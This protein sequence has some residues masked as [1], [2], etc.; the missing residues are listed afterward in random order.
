MLRPRLSL[1]A[2]L[3]CTAIGSWLGAT[4]AHATD[5]PVVAVL[6][7]DNNTGN[8]SF[9]VLKKGFA[10]M[11]ITDL[12]AIDELVVVER[13]RLQALLD[14]IKLQQAAFFDPAT[15][16][17][18]GRGLGAR[19][20]ITGAFYATTPELRIDVRMID[21]SSGQVMLA[22]KVVGAE[23]D[24][25]KLEQALVSK[26]VTGLK[27]RVLSKAMP[28]TR[29][30]DLTTLLEYSRGVDLADQGNYQAASQAMSLVIR[31]APSFALARVRRDELIK[32]LEES[33]TRR[34]QTSAQAFNAVLKSTESYF[35]K[36]GSL[37]GMSLDD[38]KAYIAFR[39]LRARFILVALGEHL[40]SGSPRVVKRGH[41]PK[42]TRL[43]KAYYDN[44]LLLIKELAEYRQLHAKT[45][46]NGTAY[47][48][49]GYK[50]PAAE[51]QLL[52]DA[53]MSEK[54]LHMSGDP[55]LALA[56]FLLMG[57]VYDPQGEHITIAPPLGELDPA[58][59]TIGFG[60]Y[61]Q[62]WAEADTLAQQQKS[63]HMDNMPHA[64]V[65]ALDQHADALLL[66]DDMRDLGIAK[67]QE[68]LDR[69]PTMAKDQ[70]ER[71]ERRIKQELGL[72]RKHDVSE[73][74]RYARGLQTC[75][76]MDLRVG[77]A[78]ITYRRIRISGLEGVDQVVAEIEKHCQGKPELDHLW[79]YLYQSAALKGAKHDDCAMF[80]TYMARAIAAGGSKSEARA[81]RKNHSRCPAPR[82]DPAAA[83]P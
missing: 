50:L 61:Q 54:L 75:V 35:K 79:P 57:T 13:E 20:A 82:N 60:L 33:R 67:L 58:Y 70:F 34:V 62:A 28:R 9:D 71:Y 59:A 74:E 38:A 65:R 11:M 45:F 83:T 73:M 3:V 8:T 36:H 16:L 25:Y 1:Y 39:A 77:L 46:A 43:M 40:S 63:T 7:F 19:Y 29:I 27:L 53:G 30:P 55:I 72:V 42:A 2:A 21:I 10:D 47:L 17:E 5:K 44:H 32:R 48:D 69:Y 76:D 23:A 64:A 26:L 41:R 56:E 52:R 18:V 81:Y 4:G 15:A 22:S 31:Q 37:R 66:R 6:Y 80:D 49:D 78:T 14:E 12:A 24:I 51:D 68:I